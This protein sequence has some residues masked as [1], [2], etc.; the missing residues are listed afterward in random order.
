MQESRSQEEFFSRIME[1]GKLDM[2][3]PD[4][5]DQVMQRVAREAKLN[6]SLSRSRK[7][8][9]VCFAL[10]TI[11]GLTMNRFVSQAIHYLF[12]VSQDTALLVSYAV[13]LL[14]VLTQL[15]NI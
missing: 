10:G 2:P 7:L 4:F 6:A 13:F 3:Y 14:L 9:I 11:F 5:E 1:R 8:A 12:P 15:D